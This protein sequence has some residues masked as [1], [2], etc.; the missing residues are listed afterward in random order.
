MASLI[1]TPPAIMNTAVRR[2]LPLAF[3]LFLFHGLAAQ[4][5][6]TLL[7]KDKI[8]L[9]EQVTVEI[10]VDGIL[11]GEI[12]NDFVFPDTVNHLEILSD[13]MQQVS[14]NGLLY[15]L[16]LTSFDSGYWQ[17]PAFEMLLANGKRLR[18]EPLGLTVLPVDVSQLQDYHDIKDI[19]EIEANNNWYLVAAIVGL[20]LFS[21]FAFLWFITR[22]R[23]SAD[24]IVEPPANLERL[25]QQ[26]ISALTELQK[27]E[28]VDRQ[29]TLQL[30]HDATGTVRKFTEQAYRR[31][32]SHLTTGEYILKMK[33]A[34]PATDITTKH[35][36]FLR[37]AD[38][39]K[40][41]KYQP[42]AEETA[43]GLTVMRGSVDEIYEQNKNRG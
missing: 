27:R 35:F 37:L 42:S 9:G 30:Y 40:F 28:T 33:P 1:S 13:T 17:L 8:V 25:Y 24:E 26:T 43:T 21:L 32:T 39:V 23:T 31:K 6:S 41:A 12:Q 11:P 5:I 15:T 2:L 4:N 38:A 18:S 34:L 22:K 10:R 29:S 19:M 16:R 20:A 7:S 36:Q 3:L 14:G